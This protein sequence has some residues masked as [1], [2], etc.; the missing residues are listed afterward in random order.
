MNFTSNSAYKY[1]LEG[2]GAKPLSFVLALILVVVIAFQLARATWMVIPSPKAANTPVPQ[3]PETRSQTA[4]GPQKLNINQLASMH[5]F[6]KKQ[7]A[8][9]PKP[10]TRQ[11][12]EEAK[13]T[14]LNLTL[15]GIFF[16]EN[17]RLGRAIIA[18]QGGKE[19]FYRVGDS[20]VAGAKL[21]QVLKDRVILMRG[22]KPE[23]LLLPQDIPTAAPQNVHKTRNASTN[24]NVVR[25]SSRTPNFTADF[26]K[27]YRDELL[28][29]PLE[30]TNLIAAAPAKRGNQQVGFRVTPGK[31][32]ELFRKMGFRSGDIVTAI[33]GIP[34]N[35]TDS[36]GLALDKLATGDSVEITVLRRG[37]P[38]TIQVNFN[39]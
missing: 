6:G 26:E 22:G 29:N 25:N 34:L 11:V 19:T 8:P 37:R 36:A 39:E 33:A 28:K 5:L 2:K 16:N 24:R 31:D 27:S 30:L 23:A 14:Q 15:K 9:P 3:N 32:P 4:S 21:D 17:P 38:R 35:E 10:T 20:I 18:D 13:E 12:V 1:W 7:I